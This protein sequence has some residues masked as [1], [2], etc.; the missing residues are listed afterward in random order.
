[1]H[2]PKV[3]S[4][5]ETGLLTVDLGFW[6][7]Y[8]WGQ[9][10]STITINVRKIGPREVKNFNSSA[11]TICID[12]GL[13]KYQIQTH[14]TRKS[15][16]YPKNRLFNP[17]IRPSFYIHLPK[18][19]SVQSIYLSPS[20]VIFFSGIW[21]NPRRPNALISSYDTHPLPPRYTNVT[22]WIDDL[23]YNCGT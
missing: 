18:H 13:S 21:R 16:R 22:P 23:I 9:F 15:L 20:T 10:L 14:F 11:S 1:M 12:H 4:A 8:Y 6:E 19:S 7:Y 2:R 17:F 5:R 3:R